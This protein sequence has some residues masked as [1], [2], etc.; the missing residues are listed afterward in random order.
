MADNQANQ[1][2]DANGN[3]IPHPVYDEEE[4]EDEEVGGDTNI[5]DSS[6]TSLPSS[7]P[8]VVFPQTMQIQRERFILKGDYITPQDAE[9]FQE[10]AQ[11]LPRL[12]INECMHRMAIDLFHVKICTDQTNLSMLT[13]EQKHDWQNILPI[14]TWS[15]L[16]TWRTESSSR[17][18]NSSYHCLSTNRVGGNSGETS[19]P[20]Q[21]RPGRLP[22]IQEE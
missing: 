18:T 4:D 21:S 2:Y 11:C 1:F 22:R 7:L 12:R 13:P 10:Q 20:W 9:E 14:R 19:R 15:S 3:P 5:L 17:I 8:T 6:Q 16:R